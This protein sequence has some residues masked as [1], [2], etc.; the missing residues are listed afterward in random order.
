[1]KPII[2]SLLLVFA[3]SA[4]CAQ[5]TTLTGIMHHSAL[6]GGCWYLTASNGKQ[7]ELVGDTGLI[8]SL[9]Y[10]GQHVSLH[11]A[12]AK[13]AASICMIGEIVRVI[14]RTDSVR[15]PVDAVIAPMTVKGKMYRTKAGLWYVK[16]TWGKKYE[17]EEPPAKKYRRVGAYYNQKV[18]VLLDTASLHEGMD[19][20]ILIEGP[21]QPTGEHKAPGKKFDPR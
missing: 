1:M 11:V 7:Y 18:R 16:A 9:R 6:E 10:E 14:A 17:F 15:M 8:N 12:P 20:K 19:G 13:G 5:E 21:H 4:A 2:A 3:I